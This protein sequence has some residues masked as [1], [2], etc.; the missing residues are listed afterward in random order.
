MPNRS[1]RARHLTVVPDLP[2]DDPATGV[3][4]P[5]SFE[6]AP[7]FELLVTLRDVE[8]SVWRRITVRS[9]L[10]LS[11]LRGVLVTAMGWQDGLTS[12][13]FARRGYPIEEYLDRDFRVDDLLPHKGET[14]RFDYGLD[15]PWVHVIELVQI[16]PDSDDSRSRCLDGAGGCPAGV[17]RRVLVPDDHWDPAGFDRAETDRRLRAP[18]LV[19]S[20]ENESIAASPLVARLLRRARPASVPQVVELLPRCELTIDSSFD[21]P[22]AQVA[23]KKT[24]WFLQ[25]VGTRGIELTATGHLPSSTV[26]AIRD[27]LDWGIG[28]HGDSTREVDHHQAT[29]LREAA[30]SLGLVRVLKGKVVRTKAGTQLADD[31]VGLWH[32]CAARLPIGRENY[33]KDA[34]TLF[35]IALAASASAEQRDAMTAHTMAALGWEMDARLA[36]QRSVAFLDLIGAHGPMYYLGRSDVEAPVWARRFARDALR[37]SVEPR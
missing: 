28:W 30:K 11:E 18:G 2:A 37:S 31:H 23:M 13:F 21:L 14:L 16:D 20:I 33:E 17:F 22:V 32:H 19:R 26:E 1:G 15:E 5:E 27:E 24:A 9:D 36:G 10:L 8:P 3:S 25:H 34:G 35:L 29:D 4:V 7:Q 6:N 12:G